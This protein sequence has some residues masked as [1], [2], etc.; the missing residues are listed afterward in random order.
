[1]GLS[2]AVIV[3]AVLTISR[4]MRVS[5]FSELNRVRRLAAITVILQ[6][7][8]F[9]EEWYTG[10]Y[11]R[12]PEMLGLAPWPSAFFTLF[13][14]SWIAIWCLCAA[15]LRSR[16]RVLSFPIWFLAIASVVNGLVIRCFLL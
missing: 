5:A 4:E 8:H 11:R 15:F 9:T 7:A 10:F 13:N 14:I 3:A 2:V 6:C 12:F 1:M 16:P